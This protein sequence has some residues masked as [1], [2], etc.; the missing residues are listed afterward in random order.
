MFLVVRII[1]GALGI[2][3]GHFMSNSSGS[4]DKEGMQK[5]KET[6]AM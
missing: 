4:I 3:I 6:P 5:G 2:G 1:L